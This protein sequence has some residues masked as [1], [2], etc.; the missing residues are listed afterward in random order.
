ML[1][2]DRGLGRPT[3]GA[4]ACRIGA[5]ALFGFYFALTLPTRPDGL[6]RREAVRRP[7]RAAVTCPGR[8]SRSARSS[9]SCS[10]RS[11]EF[12]ADAAGRGNR[13][14]AIPFGPY[15]IAGAVLAVFVAHP[16][17]QGY[18]DLVGRN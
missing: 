7:G 2:D 11:A 13:K 9:A 17:A 4:G 6:R 15:M 1:A 12:C 8:R 10:A 16:V 3:G 5:A 18:L 14:T